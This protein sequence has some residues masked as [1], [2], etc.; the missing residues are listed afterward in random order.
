M[1]T[2]KNFI[3]KNLFFALSII[4]LG[5]ASIIVNRAGATNYYVSAK[6]N[7]VADGLSPRTSWLT[8]E[9]I[10]KTKFAPGDAILFN[11][12]DAWRE[13]QALHGLSNGTAGNPIVFGAYGKGSKPLILASKD[14]SSKNF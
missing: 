6:G 11:R 5:T 13:G 14:I 8:I 1:K 3:S 9:K 10:N 2:K 7:D 12:G 4:F